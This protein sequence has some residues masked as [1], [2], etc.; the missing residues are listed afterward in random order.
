MVVGSLFGTNS[1]S[2]RTKLVV[3][4]SVTAL[5]VCAVALGVGLG[6]GLNSGGDSDANQQSEKGKRI[7]EDILSRVPLIDGH[8]DLSYHYR[9]LKN[10]TVNKVDLYTW[11]EFWAVYTDCKTQYK[12]SVKISLEQLDTIKRFVARYSD[13]FQFVTSAQAG[14]NFLLCSRLTQWLWVSKPDLR[15][16]CDRFTPQRSQHPLV[17]HGILDAFEAGKVGSL[18]GLEGGHSI[19]SSLGNLR[20]FYDLGVRYMTLTHDCNTP[21]ADNWKV[22]NDNSSQYD[23]L[24]KFGE[25]VVKEMNRLGMMVDL[26]H[27][28]Y[29]TMEDALNVTRAPVI[30]SH[31]GAYAKCQHNR[32]VRDETLSLLKANGGIIMVLF[33]PDYINCSQT[34]SLEQVADHID[35][36]KNITGADHVGIGAD[37]EGIDRAPVGLED[38][39]KYPDLFAE[40][41]RRGWSTEDLEKL[42][43]KNLI[44]V[45]KEVEKVKGDLAREDI[46]EDL[47][48]ENELINETCR[49]NF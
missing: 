39:S 37:Y 27:V 42:A 24:S 4:G 21:W 33:Y 14:G 6:V 43:G 20:L 48:P 46:Y 7:A 22:D 49:S 16:A 13:V 34:A 11:P 31:S 41:L 38:V 10:N 5:C 36:I 35:H 47:I 3:L 17:V 30:F 45:F 32:N 40:L 26:S 15:V 1:S 18:I 23:G 29:R 2:R 28:S 19:D 8:N 12:D 44:R 25:T 9:I